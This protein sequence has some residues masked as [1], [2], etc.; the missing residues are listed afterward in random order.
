MIMNKCKKRFINNRGYTMIEL[1]VALSIFVTVIIV[2]LGLFSM[3]IKGQRRVIAQQNVQENARFLMEFMAKEIR[4]SMIT[5]S[6]GTSTDL[7]L[8]RSDSDPVTYSIV[9]GKISRNGSS[10]SSEEVI[11]T[12]YFYVEGKDTNDKLQPKVTIVLGIQG[13]G[14]QVEE[15]SKMN[16]QATLSQRNLDL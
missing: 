11:V 10:V 9:D 8:T 7:T 15:K 3:A 14:S 12:G 2:V 1:M 16:I 13:V 4:M 5:S 6:N